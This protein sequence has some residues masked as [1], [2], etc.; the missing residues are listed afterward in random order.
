M[1]RI[2]DNSELVLRDLAAL[3]ERVGDVRPVLEDFGEHMVESSIPKTFQM[4]GRP[5]RWPGSPWQAGSSPNKDTGRLL[6]S[7]RSEP[8]RDRVRIG[9]N[10]KPAAIRHFGGEIKARPGK[11]LVIPLP[12]LRRS[13][14]RPSAWR[15]RL[16]R[17]PSSASPDTRGV[18][19][20][21]DKNSGLVTPRFVLRKRVTQV[22]RPFLVVVAEDEAYLRD[23]IE[24][25]VRGEG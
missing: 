17:L 5:Q 25:H 20:T 22:A 11:S 24:R 21:V 9:T 19:A 8:R 14:R 13:M 4:G 7:I 15:G 6:R 10:Y 3:K 1:I 2:T 23:S 18:L 16:V 12:G